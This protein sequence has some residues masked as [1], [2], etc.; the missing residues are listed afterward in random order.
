MPKLPN[1]ER[2]QVPLEKLRD[3]ALNS[4]HLKGG[5][6]ARVFASAL[7]LTATDAPALREMILA[8][9]LTKEAQPGVTDAH[10]ARY[11]VDFER[12]GLQGNM[13]T[14]R[15]AWIVDAGD[16]IARLVSCYVTK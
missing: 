12:Q 13:V 10:G 1:A 2:A 4:E 9:V 14:I 8:A 16:T 6:K 15:T 11:T 7:G 3:Y 5:N